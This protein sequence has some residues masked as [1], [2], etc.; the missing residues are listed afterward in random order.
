M[1]SEGAHPGGIA[2][3]ASPATAAAAGSTHTP[4]PTAAGDPGV[5]LHPQ[6]LARLGSLELRAKFIV[7]GV[8]SGMHRSPYHGFSVEFAQHR[9]YAPGDDLRHL[10]WKVYGRSDKLYLK[11]YEQE[12]NLDLVLLVDTSGSMDFGTRSYA[13]ASGTG[14]GS[15]DDGRT[16][17]TKFDHATATAAAI[18]FMALKQGDRVGL[19]MFADELIDAAD[20]SSAMAQWRRIVSILSASPVDRPTDFGRVIDQT[21]AKLNNRCLVAIISDFFADVDELRA[22]MARIKHRRHD[23]LLLQVM[24][25]RERTFDFADAAPFEGLEGEGR[26][27]LD[28]RAIR[29]AYLDE[30]ARHDAALDRAALS[31]GFDIQHINT[32]DW[33]G[34]TLAAFMARRNGALK[35]RTGR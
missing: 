21:L 26:V 12:T 28:P 25:E 10:D 30:V 31:F 14:Q 8:M 23:A 2:A 35:R 3:D 6:T 34:P 17:W 11:Q 22:A 24:D 29:A 4:T 13:S 18:A 27:R 19:G 9:Q 32:H 33:L 1:S 7:E 20:R 16:V 5:Y 15:G